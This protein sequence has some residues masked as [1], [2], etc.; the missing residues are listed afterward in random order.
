MGKLYDKRGEFQ[1]AF[2]YY[3]RGQQNNPREASIPYNLGMLFERRGMYDKALGYYRLFF[4]LTVDHTGAYAE[5]ARDLR[6]R[7]QKTYGVSY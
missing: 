3:S 7:L 1:R 2:D 6:Q 5:A 4:F